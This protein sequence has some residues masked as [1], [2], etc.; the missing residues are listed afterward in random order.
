MR[1]IGLEEWLNAEVKRLGH[2]QFDNRDE[3]GKGSCWKKVQEVGKK[4]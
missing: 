4:Y 1:I 3:Q 2:H